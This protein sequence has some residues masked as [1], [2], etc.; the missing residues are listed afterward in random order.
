MKSFIASAAILAVTAGALANIP[1][2]QIRDFS[3]NPLPGTGFVTF[4]QFDSQG[5]TRVLKAVTL[6]LA[7]TMTAQVVAENNTTSS[8]NNFGIQL[9]GSATLSTIGNLDAQLV[10][11]DSAGPVDVEAS[12]ND[13]VANGSGP[14]FHDFGLQ[15]FNDSDDDLTI[16][17]LAQFVGNGTFD[18][19]YAAQGAFGATGIS[20][21]TVTTSNFAFEG[22]ATL[23]YFYDVVPAPGAAA[24]FGFAGL[25][26]LRRRRA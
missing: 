20:N 19:D 24:L 4:N 1:E 21:A 15:K 17:N 10:F 5:G 23:T 14:D 26:G 8:S 2:V 11:A 13:G 16:F 3:V 22:T 7:G 6:E 18:A 9:N 12:D 25:A